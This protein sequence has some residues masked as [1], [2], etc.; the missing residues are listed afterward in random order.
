MLTPIAAGTLGFILI[1]GPLYN[2]RFL[3]PKWVLVFSSLMLL[4]GTI[5]F[6]RNGIHEFYWRY[7]F[8]GTVIISLGVA[9]FFINY[10]NIV[11][12]SAPP[13]DQ[14][15]ISGIIQTVAQVCTGISFAIGSS[16]ISS[17]DPK[18]LLGEY[19]KSFYV[20]M[21]FAGAGAVVAVVFVKPQAKKEVKAVSDV[22][23]MAV[24]EEN[25]SKA[26]VS[27]SNVN[28]GREEMVDA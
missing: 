24:D 7:S 11:F 26:E 22:E 9:T 21:A 16:F 12:A 8:S 19:K 2:H 28:L 10:L 5:L 1:F 3:S 6:S 17:A 4:T 13:K 25:K 14:G 15:L 27:S 20:A 23:S 18:I